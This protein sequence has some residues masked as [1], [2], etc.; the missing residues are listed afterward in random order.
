[1]NE[2]LNQPFAKKEV[3]TALVQMCHTKAV[4]PDGKPRKV[5]EFR[6]I[7]LCNVIYKIVAKNSS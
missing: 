2:E 7:S 3:T 6:S 5:A 4:G 1:M